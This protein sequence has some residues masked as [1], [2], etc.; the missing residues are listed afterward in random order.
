MLHRIASLLAVST[1][2]LI[3]I[4]GQVKCGAEAV[5]AHRTNDAIF[6][7]RT[8]ANTN[9]NDNGPIDPAELK[10]MPSH[11][12]DSMTPIDHDKARR[13][14][15]DYRNCEILRFDYLGDGHCDRVGDY[16]TAAVRKTPNNNNGPVWPW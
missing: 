12:E 10:A 9:D 16:N 13:L 14:Q 7:S 8:I 6:S 2:L 3:A 15:Q 5:V 4:A 1:V 11:G